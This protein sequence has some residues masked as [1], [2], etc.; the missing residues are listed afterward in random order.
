MCL[1]NTKVSTKLYVGFIAVLL[2]FVLC[3]VYLI[4]NMI[5]LGKMQDEGAS[6]ARDAE[7]MKSSEMMIDEVYSI[8]AD[9]IIIQ[10]LQKSK[11]ELTELKKQALR[12]ADKVRKITDTAKEKEWAIKIAEGYNKYFTVIE[13]ELLPLLEKNAGLAELATIDGQIAGLRDEIDKF[14]DDF[15]KSISNEN[16]AANKP[17]EEIRDSSIRISVILSIVGIVLV[18]MIAFVIT[19]SITGP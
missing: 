8:V 13:N 6:R 2:I 7:A 1:A 17:A 16:D 18:F 5:T 4:N 3:A 15:S 19:R 10:N 11:A 12:D 9:A 14:L